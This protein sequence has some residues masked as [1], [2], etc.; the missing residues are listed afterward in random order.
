[1]LLFGIY[2]FDFFGACFFFF[3]FDLSSFLL[4]LTTRLA[5]PL[6]LVVRGCLKV[7]AYR[8]RVS[9]LPREVS[10]LRAALQA[11]VEGG[12]G[13]RAAGLRRSLDARVAELSA[14]RAQ[15]HTRAATPIYRRSI[16][17]LLRRSRLYST[18][19][20]SPFFFFQFRSC[21]HVVF[22]VFLTEVHLNRTICL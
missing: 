17:A 8:N 3:F 21:Y 4:S 6:R 14:L 12:G 18:L 7:R 5:A 15:V 10:A 1:M 22:F 9:A 20:Y 11:D 19:L 16:G 13:N 2:I